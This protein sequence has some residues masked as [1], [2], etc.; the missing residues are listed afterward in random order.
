VTT[1]GLT[2]R[3]ATAVPAA[4]ARV[5]KDVASEGRKDVRTLKSNGDNGALITL[6]TLTPR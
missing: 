3:R 6:I 2:N 5:F 4:V 1:I